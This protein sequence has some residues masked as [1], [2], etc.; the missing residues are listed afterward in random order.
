M[1]GTR[2]GVLEVAQVASI[3]PGKA[4]SSSKRPP[5]TEARRAGG[6]G[7][8]RIEVPVRLALPIA[9][10]DWHVARGSNHLRRGRQ[11]LL[12]QCKRQRPMSIVYLFLTMPNPY[13]TTRATRAGSRCISQR[14]APP[15]WP[16]LPRVPP[17]DAESSRQIRRRCQ[18]RGS[19]DLRRPRRLLVVP[20]PKKRADD[21]LTRL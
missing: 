2:P 7:I 17:G 14:A 18:N 9:S 16:V 8:F 20:L 15:G 6:R 3:D 11:L 12:S 13:Q 10:V 21:Q 1:L 5:A 4:G 19:A